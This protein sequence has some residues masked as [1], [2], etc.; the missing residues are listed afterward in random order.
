M[1]KSII[2][3]LIFFNY[4]VFGQNDWKLAIQTWTFHKYS[5]LETIHKADTLGLKYLEV[6]PGQKAGGDIPGSFTYTLNKEERARIN[7]LLRF[8]GMQIIA[9]GVIDKY[10][11]TKDNLEQYFQFASDMNIPFITAEPEWADLD[12]FNPTQP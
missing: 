2:I 11:Y 1:F 8:K 3:L 10:Y 6:Y 7:E 9:L 5:L 12:E 4:Q